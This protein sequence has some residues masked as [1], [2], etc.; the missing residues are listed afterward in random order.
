MSALVSESASIEITDFDVEGGGGQDNNGGIIVAPIDSISLFEPH[1]YPRTLC[2]V[3]AKQGE[4][5]KAKFTPFHPLVTQQG[6]DLIC[7]GFTTRDNDIWLVSYPNSGLSWT[8]E[9]VSQ[10]LLA[11]EGSTME[12][13]EIFEMEVLCSTSNNPSGEMDT[14]NSIPDHVRRVFRSN[15][16]LDYLKRWTTPKNKLVYLTRNPKDVSVSMWHKVRT[17]QHFSIYKGDYSHFLENVFFPGRCVGGQWQAHTSDYWN[18][19]CFDSLSGKEAAE[20]NSG[21]EV[22]VISYEQLSEQPIDGVMGIAEFLEVKLTN[23]KAREVSQRCTFKIMQKVETDK[24]EEGS[25]NVNELA[26]SV[27]S[28]SSLTFRLGHIGNW[29]DYMSVRENQRFDL[30]HSI[31]LKRIGDVG[32]LNVNFG[33]EYDKSGKKS[34]GAKKHEDILEQLEATDDQSTCSIM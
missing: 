13:C 20:E 8:S 17:N 18:K 10:V 3:P 32:D 12:K 19:Y 9:I 1:T 24:L 29:M 4:V 31:I 30:L 33:D 16:S 23:V 34:K 26:G 22:Y 28:P 6:V 21:A 27:Y 15:A 25:F 5:A 2:Y 14:I 7:S 11:E